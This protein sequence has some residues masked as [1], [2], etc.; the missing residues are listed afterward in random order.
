MGE[1]AI[2]IDQVTKVF[3]LYAEKPKSLKERV[4]RAGRTP[5]TPFHA[6]ESVSFEVPQG[7][8]LA[9][10]GH[11]GSGKSTLL[12]MVAGTMRPTSGRIITRGR[13]AALLELGAGFHPDL[14]GRENVY[15]NGSILGFSK[16]QVDKIF[17]DIVE[18]S[19]INRDKNS[20][21][22]QVKHYSS[23]MYARLGFAVAINVDPDVL[24]VDEVLA[25]GDEAFQRKCLDRI[26][27]FQREGRTI[28]LVSHA[29]DTVR[30]IATRAAVFDEGRMISIGP[31]GEAIRT[32]RES[33]IA[34]GL[35]HELGD[36]EAPPVAVD[37]ATGEMPIIVAPV[38][39]VH[40][41]DAE[42]K[43]TDVD[44]EYPEANAEYMLPGQPLKIHIKYHA[45]GT[46]TDVAFAVEIYDAD[47][48]R[49]MGTTTDVLEQYIHAVQDDGEIIF[50]FEHVPLLD[51]TF[52]L[53][54]AIHTHDGGKIYDQRED[55]D[56]F[57]V[58]NP[59]RTRGLVQFPI[60]IEHLFNF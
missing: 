22:Q 2:E 58:M 15:M 55:L 14:T 27:S 31:V 28:L 18:F 51:G 19:E 25:V 39:L 17:D 4:I 30:Q 54:F 47:G 57:S 21:D 45:T 5:H 32:F 35:H 7:E 56:T 37:P 9:L 40:Q 59:T 48:N 10:L 24:I 20:I 60:K 36:M 6:L 52:R 50:Q 46:I 26:R 23:G 13:M 8:T 12:K 3:K 34:R 53:D 29:T 1:N 38:Q 49:L 44:V 41:E 11:N 42:V 16:S 43:I 33:L